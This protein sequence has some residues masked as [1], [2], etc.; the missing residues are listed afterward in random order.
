MTRKHVA[1][2]TGD[3]TLQDPMISAEL[4]RFGKN[5]VPLYLLFSPGSK[6][7]LIFPQVLTEHVVLR[8]LSRLP[9]PR[10]SSS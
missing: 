3:W 8:E 5:G 4:R 7:P 6:E 9:D 2:L 1:Y 10:A